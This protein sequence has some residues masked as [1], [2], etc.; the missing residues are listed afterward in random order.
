[1]FKL[2]KYTRVFTD[3]DTDFIVYNTVNRAIVS[4]PREKFGSDNHTLQNLEEGEIAYLTDNCFLES[5]LDLQSYADRYNTFD[6]LIISLELFLHCNLACPYCY[7]SGN[8]SRNK[9]SKEDLDALYVYIK[10]IYEHTKF[11]TLV[12]KV[13]GGEP[14]IDWKTADYIV[15]KCY[16]YCE[17]QGIF[18]KLMIDTNGT[19]VDDIISLKKYHSLTLTIPLTEKGCHNKNRKYKSGIGTYDDIIRNTNL[20]AKA[21]QNVSIVLRYNIDNENILVFEDYIN[22][23]KGKLEY[24]PIISPN[25]TMEIGKEEFHNSLKHQDV[26][27]WRSSTFVDIMA[28]NNFPIVVAPY[29]LDAKCQYLSRYSIKMFSDG[30]IGACAMSF[31]DDNRPQIRSVCDDIEK[32]P[33]FWSSAKAFNPFKDAKCCSCKSLF[34]CGGAYHLPCSGKLGETKCQNAESFHINLRLFLAKYLQYMQQG[35]DSLFVG[36]NDNNTYK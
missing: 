18:F 35:K 20:I 29:D 31:W 16:D 15:E 12:F 32:V 10:N 34:L 22:D 8:K 9:I 28:K 36:F 24:T 4:I 2:S 23:I 21:L 19:L 30:T 25:Y 5:N 3:I 6:S 26:V 1:M 7:Q 33:G 14:T 11:K 13:L 17:S 27:N